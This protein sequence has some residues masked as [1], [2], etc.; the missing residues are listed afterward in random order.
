MNLQ[1]QPLKVLATRQQV[2]NRMDYSIYLTGSTKQ[3]LDRLDMLAG[4]FKVRASNLTI[5]ALYNGQRLPSN[6]WEHFKACCNLSPILIKI[7][8]GREDFSIAEIKKGRN[9]GFCLM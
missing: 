6:D 7:I 4:D 3:E 2:V 5:E 9:L 1:V 8:E